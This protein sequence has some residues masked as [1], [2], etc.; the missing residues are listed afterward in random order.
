MQP[1]SCRLYPLSSFYLWGSNRAIL[2]AS[3]CIVAYDCIESFSVFTSL[4]AK[5]FSHGREGSWFISINVSKNL[6]LLNSPTV[7]LGRFKCKPWQ[8]QESRKS[9]NVVLAFLSDMHCLFKKIYIAFKTWNKYLLLKQ[10]VLSVNSQRNPWLN[11]HFL[12]AF[13]VFSN[14]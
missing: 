8:F 14:N 6:R 5:V 7:V 3:M 4:L 2:F 10:S 12:K 11:E 13:P 9:R 1:V